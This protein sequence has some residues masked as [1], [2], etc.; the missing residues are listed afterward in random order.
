MTH[1]IPTPRTQRRILRTILPQFTRG[2]VQQFRYRDND[3]TLLLAARADA[4]E[5][6]LFAAQ[7]TIRR[8]RQDLDYTHE[9]VD[10]LR[11][12]NAW[13]RERLAAMA[14]VSAELRLAEAFC[15]WCSAPA[16]DVHAAG[17]RRSSV[18]HD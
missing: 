7:S 13:L 4:S 3:A 1:R 18:T 8:M 10:E 2:A 5:R 14:R 11:G 15:P 16:G 17:C 6:E 12:E 9:R